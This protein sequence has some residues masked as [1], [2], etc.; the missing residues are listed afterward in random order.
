M[1]THATLETNEQ[2]FNSINTTYVDKEALEIL[3]QRFSFSTNTLDE[4]A[5]LA[6]SLNHWDIVTRLIKEGISESLVAMLEY[7]FQEKGSVNVEH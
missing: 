5:L 2:L 4:A 7:E 6:G 3:L 1:N